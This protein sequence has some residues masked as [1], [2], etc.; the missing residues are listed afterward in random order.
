MLWNWLGLTIYPAVAGLM[1][2]FGIAVTYLRFYK[3]FK[4]QGLDRSKLP[5]ASP[6]QPYAAW[7]ALCACVFICFVRL[8]CYPYLF[9]ALIHLL[10]FS[11]WAVFLRDSWDTATFVTNYLPLMLFPVLYIG[12]KLW[13]RDSIKKPD[14]MDF[15][16]GLAE[17]EAASYDEP[18][19]RNWLERFWSWLVSI[20]LILG[21]V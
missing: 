21:H 16:S 18:P 2:W 8:L 13:R 14:D 3:G 19:P 7:Y 10:Q 6:L 1:T 11:G 9:H 15:Y 4:R 20:L 12:A 5:Y 17:V